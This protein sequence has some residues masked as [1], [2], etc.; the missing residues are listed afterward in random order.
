MDCVQNYGDL[1]QKNPLCTLSD[2][3]KAA[4]I[5]SA[6]RK[7]M[8]YT[9]SQ[10]NIRLKNPQALRAPVLRDISMSAL[11][12]LASRASVL[13]TF[14]FGI[15]MFASCFDKSIA[16][17]GILMMCAGLFSAASGIAMVKY[18]IA[19]LLFWIYIKM[20][21]DGNKM[22]ESAACGIAVMTG[23]MTIL[24]YNYIGFYDIM[25][26]LVESI[27]TAIMYIIFTKARQLM[28]TQ[29][30]RKHA[31]QEELIS[32]AVCA[33]VF[34]TGFSG[35]KLPYNISP[36]NIASVYAVLCMA[37]HGSL[38][39]AGSGGM[40][41]GFMSAMATNSA[42]VMTGIYG[43]S[44]LFANLLRVFRKTGVAV[45]MLAGA[46][47]SLIYLQSNFTVPLMLAEVGIGCMLFM[48]T[49]KKVH[50]YIKS[51]FS[52]SVKM[53]EISTELRMKAYL[54][55]RLSAL[56]GAF[57]SLGKC[58]K[59]TSQKR[60]QIYNRE[61]GGIFDEAARRSCEG[62]S[63]AVKCWQSDYSRTYKYIMMLLET[64]EKKGVLTLENVP[65]LFRDKC[66]RTDLFVLEFNHVYELYRKDMLRKN[67]AVTERDIVA[68]QY[69]EI[70]S[71]AGTIAE[72]IKNGF[73]FRED[74]EEQI[75][76]ELDRNGIQVFEISVVENE[77]GKIEVY[78]SIAGSFGTD[79][80]SQIL[81][82][83]TALQMGPDTTNK[84]TMMKFVSQPRFGAEIGICGR[85]SDYS[86]VSGD[87]LEVFDTDSNMKYIILSDGMGSGEE[88]ASQSRLTLKLLKEFLMSGFG[89]KTSVNMINSSLCLKLDKETFATIDLVGINLMNGVAEFYKIGSAQSLI[90]HNGD[91]D[92]VFSVTPPVGIINDIKPFG[93]TKLL[94][95]G[96]TILM[97]SDGVS[98]AGYGKVR[99][100]WMKKQVL[101]NFDTMEEMAK[102]VIDTAVKKC[103]NEI[104]DD[105]TVA[106]IRLFEN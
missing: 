2:R 71:I 6:V 57:K 28:E 61:I 77:L 5:L 29:Q 3:G 15:A 20:R 90:Y 47:I 46:A 87:C 101:K 73:R 53:E 31:S 7:V 94:E 37:Y 34:I 89:V 51:F 11:L 86:D 78:L 67:E 52:R 100:E 13:G 48:L 98:Q 80:I 23:G 1:F 41:I 75:V 42:I 70:S 64:I 79:K 95:D 36:A 10:P 40:C 45:G 63:M 19:A 68:E 76:A 97:M 12:F 4:P 35:I 25:V 18:V 39:A 30:S 9:M 83:I 96:D 82:E 54:S 72:E 81:T 58:F 50:S 32:V 103:R 43:L 27:V 8:K 66:I 59:K 62:C 93:Q 99:T 91:V 44:A 105:M 102:S 104:T 38:A 69:D 84:G 65:K 26:L 16:Y 60:L 55:M 17:V 88:A 22:T 56:S 49:P 33:G 106:A 24:I 85:K 21:P 92:T 14:P 74:Y